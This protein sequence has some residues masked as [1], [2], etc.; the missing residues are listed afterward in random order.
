MTDEPLYQKYNEQLQQ[1]NN[2]DN[3]KSNGKENV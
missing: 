1:I 3:T 2:H